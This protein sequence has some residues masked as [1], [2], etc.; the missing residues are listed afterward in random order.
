M[1]PVK[2]DLFIGL[3]TLKGVISHVQYKPDNTF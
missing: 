3:L 1:W 2:Y